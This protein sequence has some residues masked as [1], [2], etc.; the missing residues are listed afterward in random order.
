M[1]IYEIFDN[2]N[3]RPS[4]TREIHIFFLNRIIDAALPKFRR[5]ELIKQI[6]N[7]NKPKLDEIYQKPVDSMEPFDKLYLKVLAIERLYIYPEKL[8]LDNYHL[9]DPRAPKENSILESKKKLKGSIKFTP[10]LGADV[11]DTDFDQLPIVNLKV[12]DIRLNEPYKM[13]DPRSKRTVGQLRKKI[14][15][16]ITLSPILVRKH[17]RGYQVLDGHHR[18]KAY[19][20]LDLETIPARIVP[21]AN[22]K[23]VWTKDRSL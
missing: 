7:M 16:G 6:N 19:Q 8:S 22:I 18:L 21:N 4:L 17:T 13:N 9:I 23:M 5:Q 1:R 10:R 15:Q 3:Q 11:D 14:K 20:L 2:N 12:A